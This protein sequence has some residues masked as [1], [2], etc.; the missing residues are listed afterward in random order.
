MKRAL[1]KIGNVATYTIMGGTAL[2]SIAALLYGVLPADATQP[3]VD[4][5]NMNAQAIVPVGISSTVAAVTLA[6]GKIFGKTVN[7][8]L[9]Q[10]NLSLKLWETDVL[11]KVNTQ[12]KLQEQ[13]ND[14]VAQ[15]QN[16]IIEQNK[17]LISQQNAILKFNEITAIRNIASPLVPDT[18]KEE[19]KV[20]IGNLTSLKTNYTPITKLV[21][22][23][24]IKEVEKE[25]TDKV[26][27]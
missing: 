22:E 7:E 16:Q 17:T 1:L 20:A 9:H 27:W 2:Y 15:K 10:S 13:L 25:T 11:S 18:V 12:F 8:K 19:Y 26:S 5:L 6:V 4:T 21:E 3:I 23:T 24:I 14:V